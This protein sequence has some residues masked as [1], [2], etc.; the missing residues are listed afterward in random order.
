MN[1][2]TIA[3]HL[4]CL[5]ASNI[6]KILIPYIQFTDSTWAAVSRPEAAPAEEGREQGQGQPQTS[7]TNHSR[8]YGI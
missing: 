8:F 5:H 3:T 1:Y 2:W 6:D 7:A 4:Y